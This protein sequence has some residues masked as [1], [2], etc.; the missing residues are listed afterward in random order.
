MKI[1]KTVQK[2]LAS[3]GYIKNQSSLNIRQLS[4]CF[5]SIVAIISLSLYL[6]CFANTQKEFMDSIFMTVS[7]VLVFISNLST[8]NK[9]T[10]IFIFIDRTEQVINESKFLHSFVSLEMNLDKTYFLRPKKSLGLKY[11]KSKKM[12][13][14][15]NRLVEKLCKIA[16]FI[17]VKVSAPCLAIPKA[18]L[19]FF[20]YFTTDLG[21]NAF[22]LPIPAW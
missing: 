18:L 22:E 17:I 13:K 20:M 16:Y 6:F 5:L 2:H 11:P 10:T 9:L 14:K 7:G 3:L 4:I 21:P 8:A 15:T 19:S 12:Y 1:F